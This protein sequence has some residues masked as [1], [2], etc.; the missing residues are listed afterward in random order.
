MSS[1][2]DIQCIFVMYVKISGHNFF[3]KLQKILY[4]QFVQI[5]ILYIGHIYR[6]NYVGA[7]RK[8]HIKTFNF[9]YFIVSFFIASSVP[10]FY[11]RDNISPYKV[12][13]PILLNDLNDFHYS[14]LN[15]LVGIFRPYHMVFNCLLM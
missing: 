11:P 3:E 10:I 1:L 6:Q 5:C 7:Y 14:A 13:N 8:Q 12:N 2:N 15:G 4:L 9:K